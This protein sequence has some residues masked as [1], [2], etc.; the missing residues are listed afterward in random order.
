MKL[1]PWCP[2]CEDFVDAVVYVNESLDPDRIGIEMPSSGGLPMKW[3][4]GTHGLSDE[5]VNAANKEDDAYCTVHTD[6]PVQWARCRDDG[7]MV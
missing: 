3:A 7:S 1:R 4:D 2:T 6:T 5:Q